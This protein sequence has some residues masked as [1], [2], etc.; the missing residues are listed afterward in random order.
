MPEA[1]SAPVWSTEAAPALDVWS[2]LDGSQEAGSLQ[3]AASAVNPLNYSQPLQSQQTSTQ[4]EG[5]SLETWFPQSSASMKPDDNQKETELPFGDNSLQYDGL[6]EQNANDIDT[7]ESQPSVGESGIWATSSKEG[8]MPSPPAWLNMLTQSEIQQLNNGEVPEPSP[9][10][11]PAAVILPVQP[12][13]QK[14]KPKGTTKPTIDDD[15]AL[16]FGPEWLKSMGAASLEDETSQD[17]PSVIPKMDERQPSRVSQVYE[18]QPVASEAAKYEP[19]ERVAQPIGTAEYNLLTTLEGLEA[20]L[21]SQGFVPLQPNSLQ[22]IAKTQETT[23]SIVPKTPEL[24]TQQEDAYQNA[25]LPSALAELGSFAQEPEWL[26]SLN[27]VSAPSLVT[28][29]QQEMLT[30]QEEQI[31]STLPSA[32]PFWTAA[33]EPHRTSPLSS[34][35]EEEVPIPHVEARSVQP[36]QPLKKEPAREEPVLASPIFGTAQSM[37]RPQEIFAA[38]LPPP[39]ALSE[40]GELARQSSPAANNDPLL[41]SE[42]ETT[43]KRPAVRLQPMQPERFFAQNDIVSSARSRMVDQTNSGRTAEGNGSYQERLLKGYQHQLVGDYDEAMQEYRIIIRNSPELLGEVVSNVR[44]LLKLAPKYSTG[45]RVLGD[46]YMRQGEYLQAMEAYN[47]A[48][49]MAKRAKG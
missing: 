22:A 11:E 16:S 6:K 9:V 26:T 43:M 48:L 10:E 47:K 23:S 41:N 44:A 8:S 31:Y 40:M 45:Y 1:S 18:P 35:Q 46:A 5:Q 14:V 29:S 32:Q 21:L 4:L 24:A 39:S 2:V 3:N 12:T 33:Y 37:N 34:V 20:G 17:V 49:T 7:W 30:Q 28:S 38:P 15:E 13:A 42:L 27:T 36:T 19:Q 25:S